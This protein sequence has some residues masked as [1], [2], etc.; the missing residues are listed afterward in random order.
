LK[1]IKIG[2]GALLMLGS[3]II[4]DRAEILILYFLSAFLHECGH[5]LA[6]VLLGIGVKEIRFEFSGIRI[7]TDEGLTS[8]KSEILLAAAG[9]FVNFICLGM[10]MVAFLLSGRTYGE[11]TA[12]AEAFISGREYSSVGAVSFFAV[13][14]FLQGGL[15]LLPVRSFDGGRILYC[16][17]ALLLGERV[18]ERVIDVLSAF[19]ALVLWTVALYLLLKVG[20]GLGIYVFAACIAFSVTR[21][22]VN[23][24]ESA[25]IS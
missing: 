11:V 15:N 4:S 3:M 6:A 1:R 22:T 9:P 18:A 8:Y 14:A 7:C 24:K 10:C 20:S 5:L 16:C 17:V 23:E 19:S 25:V 21:E 13:S 12:L 2:A